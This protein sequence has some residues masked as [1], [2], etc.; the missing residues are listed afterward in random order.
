MALEGGMS[1]LYLSDQ[2]ARE[3][4]GEWTVTDRSLALWVGARY[5]LPPLGRAVRP[6]LRL[7]A[8]PAAERRTTTVDGR[9]AR[10]YSD[11]AV[12]GFAG[13]GVDV[14]L[15]RRLSLGLHLGWNFSSQERA[16]FRLGLG[17]GVSTRARSTAYR[18]SGGVRA[19]P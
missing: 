2:P 12:L 4:P 1:A 14:R 15:S 11:G 18:G 3:T 9:P 10:T 5:Y 7:T 6:F 17:L 16:A 19:E 13:A 8:G